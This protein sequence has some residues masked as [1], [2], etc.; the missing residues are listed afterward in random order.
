MDDTLTCPVCGNKLRTINLNNKYLHP[1]GK[2]G[3]YIERTC[4]DGMNHSLQFFWNKQS[5]KIE[6]LKLSLNHKYS[7]YLEIDFVNEKC[8]IQCMK[9]GK[10][11]H[12]EIDKIIVPDFPLLEKLKEKVNFYILFS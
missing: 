12:I 7:R 1:V 4:S 10:A 8:K 5:K 9:N 11:E 2:N 6:L 3:D